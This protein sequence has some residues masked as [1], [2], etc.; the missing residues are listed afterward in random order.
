MSLHYY[1]QSSQRC[2]GAGYEYMLPRDKATLSGMIL[3]TCAP[4]PSLFGPNLLDLAFTRL[5]VTLLEGVAVT[6]VTKFCASQTNAAGGGV[7]ALG[8]WRARDRMGR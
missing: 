3:R 5:F 2:V 6:D 4:A 1:I 7:G 8:D